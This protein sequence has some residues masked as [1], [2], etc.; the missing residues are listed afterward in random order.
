MAD[1]KAV[2]NSR[3]LFNE[4]ETFAPYFICE[5]SLGVDEIFEALV[6]CITTISKRFEFPGP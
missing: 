4:T 1:I 3:L 6:L 5:E 2:L